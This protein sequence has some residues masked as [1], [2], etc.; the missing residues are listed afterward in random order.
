MLGIKKLLADLYDDGIFVHVIQ[1]YEVSPCVRYLPDSVV[2]LTGG[3]HVIPR[4]R[5]RA[6]VINVTWDLWRNE[7]IQHVVESEAV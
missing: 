2:F 3:S 7:A 4:N 5:L 6:G 1:N